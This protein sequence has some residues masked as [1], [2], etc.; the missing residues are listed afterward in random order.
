MVRCFWI[1]CS[2]LT[3]PEVPAQSYLSSCPGRGRSV[4]MP[5]I[6]LLT[7][8]FDGGMRSHPT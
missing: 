6:F 1:C 4:S 7:A 8:G 5:V 3:F 2:D